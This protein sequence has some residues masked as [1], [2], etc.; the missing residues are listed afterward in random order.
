MINE[1]QNLVMSNLYHQIKLGQDFWTWK[2]YLCYE[3]FIYLMGTYTQKGHSPPMSSFSII[4]AVIAAL[5][6]RVEMIR[7]TNKIQCILIIIHALKW[8]EWMCSWVWI[9]AIVWRHCETS[10]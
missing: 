10:N 2:T 3:T 7:P 1:S 9:D 5:T 6:T 8:W 4:I